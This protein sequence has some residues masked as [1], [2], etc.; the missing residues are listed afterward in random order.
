[1]HSEKKWYVVQTKPR[2][3][4]EAEEQLRRQGF[5]VYLPRLQV[6]KLRNRRWLA[7]VEPMFPR[8]LF[9][10]LDPNIDSIAP[11]R[12]T[13][14]VSQIVRFG[15]Q[16]CPVPDEVIQF[17][18]QRE[19]PENHCSTP[20][21]VEFSKGETVVVRDGPFA[22]MEGIFE[23]HSGEERSIVLL[24]CLGQQN[25][26]NLARHSVLPKVS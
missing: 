5:G 19:N 17:L 10:H 23:R 3:E 13:R 8:Y 9:V 24:N 20:P 1:M 21:P 7:T 22:G 25:R 2:K 14:G 12:S 15:L 4:Y 26:I 11:V 16:L 18:Q 6:E